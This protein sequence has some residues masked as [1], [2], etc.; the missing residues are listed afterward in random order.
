MEDTNINVKTLDAFGNEV[1][2]AGL[3]YCS[4]NTTIVAVDTDI[5][6][7]PVL[8]G[9]ATIAIF[10]EQFLFLIIFWNAYYSIL[11]PIVLKQ[12]RETQLIY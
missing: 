2:D 12:N 6:L 9:T 5:T 4:N 1:S 3:V 7:I 8:A 11:F 10:Q